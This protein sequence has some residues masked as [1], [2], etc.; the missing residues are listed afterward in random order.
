MPWFFTGYFFHT[1]KGIKYTDI[2][3][4]ILIIGASVGC[5]IA[6]IPNIFDLSL[7]FS[8]IGYIPFSLSLFVIAL[9]YPGIS[10]CKCLEYIGSRLSL[11]IYVFHPIIGWLCIDCASNILKIDTN[12]IV[13]S[14]C[15][16]FVVLFLSILF[17]FVID[18]IMQS[19]MKKRLKIRK[20]KG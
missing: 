8:C 16:P 3:T 13:F 9:K 10:L 2:K 6:I 20:E 1:K 12:G 7:D 14:W 4:S 17:S 15:K 5:L 18:Q 19:I 11:N